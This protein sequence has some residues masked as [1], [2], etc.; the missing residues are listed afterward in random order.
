MCVY[1][2]FFTVSIA[3]SEEFYTLSMYKKYEG[4]TLNGLYI[5][6]VTKDGVGIRDNFDRLWSFN[7]ETF[8]TCCSYNKLRRYLWRLENG[9]SMQE[10]GYLKFNYTELE[11]D[12]LSVYKRHIGENINGITILFVTKD[13]VI[14]KDEEENFYGFNPEYLPKCACFSNRLN[15]V[16]LRLTRGLELLEGY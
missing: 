13:G 15:D 16:I 3:F 9:I 12:P 4:E 2:L 6:Y 14:V 11:L 7:P 8:P 10:Y 1:I 5:R